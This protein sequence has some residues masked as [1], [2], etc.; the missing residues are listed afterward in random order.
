MDRLDGWRV[1]TIQFYQ[2]RHTAA[3]R[4]VAIEFV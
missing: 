4:V 2:G 3:S 1:S